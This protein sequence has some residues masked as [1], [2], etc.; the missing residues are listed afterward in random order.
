[1]APRK[2][3]ENKQAKPAPGARLEVDMSEVTLLE[4][5]EFF[6]DKV[7]LFAESTS[8]T[9][10]LSR[11]VP[12]T[13]GNVNAG[14]SRPSVVLHLSPQTA[15]DLSALLDDNVKKHEAAWGTIETEYTK[16]RAAKTPAPEAENLPTAE[17]HSPTTQSRKTRAKTRKSLQ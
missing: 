6:G 7:A 5:P 12:I 14:M 1:M 2:A 13:I 11:Q 17:A 3:S 15:K 8:F 10:V 4:V 16:R 9:V